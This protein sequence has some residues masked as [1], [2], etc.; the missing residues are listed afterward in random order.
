M[1]EFKKLTD[2]EIA[3]LT[4]EELEKYNAD[5]ATWEAE[6]A[7]AKAK[8]DEEA[9]V[10]AEVKTKTKTKTDKE[11]K[12]SEYLSDEEI[13]EVAK[14][15]PTIKEFFITSDKTPFPSRWLAENHNRNREVNENLQHVK[16]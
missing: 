1:A 9:K 11:A 12:A 6:Q 7:D 3:K 4:P 2:K 14:N 13:A 15:N 8:A 16:I 10:K 5:L